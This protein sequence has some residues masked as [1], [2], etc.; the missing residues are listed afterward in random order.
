[1]LEELPPG[2]L[3][4]WQAYYLVEPDWRFQVLKV[5]KI[6]AI[7]IAGANGV[8]LKPEDLEIPSWDGKTKGA[9]QEEF[10]GPAAARMM[11]ETQVAS[12][13]P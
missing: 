3:D 2:A 5:L 7:T 4:E 8:T 10:L 6:I 9:G 12:W 11:I 1:M 13:Q